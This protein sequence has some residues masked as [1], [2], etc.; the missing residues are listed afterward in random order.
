MQTHLLGFQSTLV[1]EGR[2]RERDRM[3]VGNSILKGTKL[4][5]E[6]E[7]IMGLVL[8]EQLRFTHL[9]ILLRLLICFMHGS[10]W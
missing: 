4:N 7:D 10:V 3:Y 8:T 9:S 1:E 5:H 6:R 2:E